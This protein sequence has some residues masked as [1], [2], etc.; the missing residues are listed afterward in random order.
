MEI[1]NMYVWETDKML[2]LKPYPIYVLKKIYLLQA[3]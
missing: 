3:L 1:I 2:M